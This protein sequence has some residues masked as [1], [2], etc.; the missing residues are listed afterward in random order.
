MKTAVEWLEEIA[1]NGFITPEDFE[2]AK[3]MEKQQQELVWKESRVLKVVD[4]YHEKE[5]SFEDYYNKTLK[6]EDK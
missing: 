2:Q 4:A 1:M 5:T 6:S 3:E